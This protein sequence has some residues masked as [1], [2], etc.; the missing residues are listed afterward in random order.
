MKFTRWACVFLVGVCAVISFSLFA[1]TPA[2]P[3]FE[4]ASIKPLPPLE[5]L[6]Q[7]LISGKGNI[8]KLGTTIDATR[9]D[10]GAATLKE[11]FQRAY[12]LKP[13]Q[14]VG[15]DWM[16]AQ[17]YEIHAKLP[18]GAAKEQ[19]PAMLQTL[20][21]E[22]FKIVS[23]RENKEQPVYALLVSGEGHK[24]KEATVEPTPAS[25]EETPVNAPAA[26]NEVVLGGGES[27]IKIKANK[28]GMEFSSGEIGQIRVNT[29]PN[30]IVYE[31][32]KMKMSQFATVLSTYVDR[33]V[34]DRTELKGAYE[35]ALEISMEEVMAMA[36]KQ[37][38]NLGINLPPGALGGGS[39]SGLGA[40][41]LG[42]SDPAGA[43]IFKAVQKLGLKLDSQKAP[44]ET[45]VIDHIEQ[46]PTED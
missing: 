9:V 31:F 43:G 23:H 2:K 1:Q 21:E 25:P 10:I 46:T 24:L 14:I 6:M 38:P 15:P 44:V 34:V 35:M 17:L 19:V 13:Y 39:S 36:Q 33:P 37:L 30:G 20:L 32:S 18:E 42:A 12:D 41:G 11:L 28:G 5:N 40:G 45:L 3:A 26:K 27:Q 22:R 4:V 29:T 16:P 8:Q 7:D